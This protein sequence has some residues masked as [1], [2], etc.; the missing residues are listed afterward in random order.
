MSSK[1][2]VLPAKHLINVGLLGTNVAT[3]GGFMAFAPTAPLIGALF[4]AGSAALSFIKGYT[5]TAAIGGA[6]MR[7]SFLML[8]T[9]VI[10]LR[11][12]V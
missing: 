3:L 12:C 2:L 11:A 4:L 10:E 6:D 1:P 7:E 8:T 9:L 5:L